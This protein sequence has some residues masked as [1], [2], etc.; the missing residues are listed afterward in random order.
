MEVYS[1][2]Y[3]IFTKSVEVP[4]INFQCWLV[5]FIS[6]IKQYHMAVG[7]FQLHHQTQASCKKI[8]Q[9]PSCKI[10]TPWA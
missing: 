7:L 4:F 2:S 6:N 8:K 9:N 10:S 1:G 5:G 3:D